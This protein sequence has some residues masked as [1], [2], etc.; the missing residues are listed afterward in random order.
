MPASVDNLALGYLGFC[1]VKFTGY[2][3]AAHLLSGSY[4]QSESSAYL[5]GGVRTL[6]GMFV[7]AAYFGLWSLLSDPG[8]WLFLTGLIPIRLAEWGLLIWLFY[9]RALTDRSKAWRCSGFGTFWSYLLDI[10]A[11]TGLLITG[12]VSIC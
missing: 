9:D 5:V 1:A 3:F 8:G 12:G 7:G 10:P 2:S 4:G 11:I 6:I